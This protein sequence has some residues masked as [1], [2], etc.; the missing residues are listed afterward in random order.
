MVE[1]GEGWIERM[2]RASTNGYS[3]VFFRRR[4]PRAGRWALFLLLFAALLCAGYTAY[5]NGRCEVKRQ[6]VFVADL[7]DALEGFTVLHVSDLGGKTFGQKDAEITRALRSAKWDAVVCTGNML[8]ADGDPAAFYDLI[9]AIGTGK[10]FYFLAGRSDPAPADGTNARSALSE[11]VLGAQS[12]GAV[13]LDRPQKIEKGG[14]SVWLTEPSLL[15]LD[16]EGALSAYA[17]AGTAGAAYRQGV[18]TDTSA[19]RKSMEADCG[20]HLLVSAEPYT[21]EAM[22][23]LLASADGDFVR[24]VDLIFAGG[25]AGGQWRLPGGRGVWAQGTWFPKKALAGYGYAGGIL[26]YVSGG[27]GC[28][29]ASPLPDFRLFNTPEM[30][31]VTFTSQIDLD[32]LPR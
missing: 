3:N 30:T 25:T 22:R 6:R 15:T 9:A 24:T 11:W 4:R 18:I 10:P 20:L 32:T 16:L 14:E 29:A 28:G 26:Q 13:Y 5:D 12:R 23:K 21:D 31:L 8:G 17:Q 2:Y 27:L 7:P 19:A 1:T